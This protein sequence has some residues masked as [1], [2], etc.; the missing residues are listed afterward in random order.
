VPPVQTTTEIGM[1]LGVSILSGVGTRVTLTNRL[2]VYRSRRRL[3]KA[4]G[5]DG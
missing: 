1:L 5:V 4:D 3:E 2:H